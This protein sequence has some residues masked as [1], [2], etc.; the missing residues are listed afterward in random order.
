MGN[1]FGVV[2]LAS[3]GVA[4]VAGSIELL[5]LVLVA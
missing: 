1:Y 4:F 3:I 5:V 2:E